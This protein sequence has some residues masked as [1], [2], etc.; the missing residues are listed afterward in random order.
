MTRPHLSKRPEMPFSAV[1]GQEQ[2]KL[3]LILVAINPAIGGVVISGP[4]GCAK[5]TLARAL[6]DILPSSARAS[7]VTLPLGASEE[8]LV[9]TLNL[10]KVLNDKSLDFSPGLLSKAHGGVLYVDE[11]N[12]LPDNLV[13]LLLDVASSGTNFVERDGISHQHKAEFLLVGTMNPDEGELRPQ[14]HDRF[15]LAV[16]LSNRYPIEE[17]VAIVKARESFEAN[18]EA[19]TA[20]YAEQQSALVDRISAARKLLAQVHCNDAIRLDIAQRCEDAKVDGLRADITWYRAA[21]AHAAW[22]ERTEVIQEDVDVVAELVLSHRRREP[23]NT[24]PPSMPPTNPPSEDKSEKS[25]DN[26]TNNNVNSSSFKRPDDTHRQQKQNDTNEA[27]DWGRKEPSTQHGI[28]TFLG[29]LPEHNERLAKSSYPS[30]EKVFAKRKGSIGSGSTKSGTESDNPNWFSSL[31]SSLGEW[32]PKNL[33]MHK[34]RKGLPTLHVLL[35]DTSGSV[36]QGEVFARTK[37]VVA[38]ITKEAYLKREQLAVFGFGNNEVCSLMAKVR[39]PKQIETWLDALQAGGGTP[40]R[41]SIEVIADYCRKMDQRYSGIN[42]RS[43][44]I[45]DGRS[46]DELTSLSFPCECVWI[47]TEQAPIARGR[48]KEFAKHL[49][50][51]YISLKQELAHFQPQIQRAD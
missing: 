39:A 41:Q 45:S 33:K 21:L 15:G 51:I 36:L 23:L 27:G 19:F 6:A 20:S 7:F 13:D 1:I 37:G 29:E 35:V 32:P 26:A 22:H 47:D 31:I 24:P 10:E 50:A 18:P 9:G 34:Q 25:P 17:R 2:F 4:R 12:L 3:A 8:M 14:L 38:S 40:I 16:D 48:G 42:I 30:L 43:Y 49:G 5:S 44:I 28:K 11:V 46:R